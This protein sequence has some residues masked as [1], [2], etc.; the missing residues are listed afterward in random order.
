[1][2]A[3]DFERRSH[4]LFSTPPMSTSRGK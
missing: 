2:P 3:V 4:S 1:V